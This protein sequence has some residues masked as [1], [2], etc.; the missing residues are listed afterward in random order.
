MA[1]TSVFI[2]MNYLGIFD[3]ICMH[4]EYVKSCVYVKRICASGK[5]VWINRCNVQRG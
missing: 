2:L 1:D 4:Y 5:K 3:K